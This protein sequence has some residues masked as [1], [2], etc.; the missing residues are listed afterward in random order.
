MSAGE[1]LRF[2]SSFTTTANWEDPIPLD[3]SNSLLIVLGVGGVLYAFATECWRA[4]ERAKRAR[5]QTWEMQAFLATF[6]LIW[7]AVVAIAV[8]VV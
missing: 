6:V 1:L 8:E 7:I 5:W 4:C 2:V 3:A